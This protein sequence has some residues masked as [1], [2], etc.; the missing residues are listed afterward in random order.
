MRRC[1]TLLALAA[2]IACGVDRGGS[3]VIRRD[4]EPD[5]ITVSATD[6]ELV[7]ARARA[8][9]TYPQ[10]LQML[11]APDSSDREVAVKLIFSRGDTVEYLWVDELD[12]TGGV[13]VGRVA[14]VPV[15]LKSIAYG[16]SVRVNPQHVADWMLVREELLVGGFT[17]RVYRQRMTAAE[18]VRYDSAQGYRIDD[19]IVLPDGA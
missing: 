2:C 15:E 16:D 6:P 5:A 3:E 7:A 17:S 14:N 9:Q 4:G 13:L 10:F 1:S 11:V 8:Q 19:S 18:R 12:L